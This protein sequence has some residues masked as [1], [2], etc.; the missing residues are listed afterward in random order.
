MPPAEV[1]GALGER[2]ILFRHAVLMSAEGLLMTPARTDTDGFFCRLLRC[3]AREMP[4][5][6]TLHIAELARP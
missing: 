2:A 4:V 5:S 3:E 1:A 6:G